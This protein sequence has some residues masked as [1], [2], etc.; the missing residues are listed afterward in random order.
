MNKYRMQIRIKSQSG[1]TT[2]VW[3]TV[4]ASNPNQARDMALSMYNA[5]QVVSGPN[6]VH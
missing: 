6:I 2:L 1:G 3:I 5:I 4:D